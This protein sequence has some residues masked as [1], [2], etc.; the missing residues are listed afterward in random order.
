MLYAM[1]GRFVALGRVDPT[2]VSAVV[3]ECCDLVTKTN[4]PPPKPC[5]M[6]GALSGRGWYQGGGPLVHMM[7]AGSRESVNES[8]RAGV[9]YCVYCKAIGLLSLTACAGEARYDEICQV[10]SSPY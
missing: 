2:E 1:N 8:M 9:N 5:T 3:W 6:H 7:I 4:P 10:Q